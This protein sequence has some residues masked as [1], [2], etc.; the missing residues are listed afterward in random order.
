[1]FK[2]KI[3][4]SDKY[5]RLRSWQFVLMLLPLILVGWLVNAYLLPVW[6]GILLFVAFL[7]ANVL[8]IRNQRLMK[9]LTG[10]IVVEA[11][12]EMICL[13]SSKGAAIEQYRLADVEILVKD[14]YGLPGEN[15]KEIGEEIRGKNREN[16][17][18]IKSGDQQR[19][20]DFEFES[21]YMVRQLEKV[22]AQWV[23]AGHR[24]ERI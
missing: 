5:Y 10:S 16:Y 14:N 24:L 23:E 18:I 4:N 17:L 20:I 7:A 13:K 9:F 1:M 19:R 2:A 3:I 21:Y 11:D 6:L 8:L 15:L 12:T 22:I